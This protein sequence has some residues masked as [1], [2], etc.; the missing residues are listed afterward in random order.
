MITTHLAIESVQDILSVDLR[1]F[2]DLHTNLKTGCIKLSF[3][4][5][6]LLIQ[7]KEVY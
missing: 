4:V 1:F 6:K 5:F 7:L 3:S 2:I